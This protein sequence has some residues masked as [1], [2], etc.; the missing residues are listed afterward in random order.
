MTLI[1]GLTGGI[2]SGKTS[3]ANFFSVLGIDIVDTDVIA[4]E[5][6][7]PKG[8]AIDAI[9][10]TFTDRFI[11]A[12]GALNREEMRRLVFSDSGSRRKL[13]TILH[14]LIRDEASRRAA[15]FSAPYG[16]VV[17]PLLLETGQYR[18]LIHRILLVDCD[19]CDQ[20][21]R[22]TARTGLDESTVRA[23]MATQLSR[24]ERLQQADD[25][26]TNDA[27]LPHL[28]R[29]VGVLHEKYLALASGN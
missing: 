4:H 27:D 10:Q 19:E 26:I 12:E 23:I 18:E 1:I 17:V 13:E 14:P 29:Q 6:T 21:A 7:Q 24:E 25:V 8:A 28:A 22:A 3:A 20:I 15:L 16:I 11:T 5:L 2:G 9:R